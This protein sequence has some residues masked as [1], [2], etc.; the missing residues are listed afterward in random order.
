[1]A[2]FHFWFFFFLFFKH[3]FNGNNILKYSSFEN[4][5]RK[6][7]NNNSDW[8]LDLKF[9]FW[10]NSDAYCDPKST[11]S[12]G[13]LAISFS[14]FSCKFMNLMS[15]QTRSKELQRHFHQQT[16]Y[17]TFAQFKAYYVIL[18]NTSLDDANWQ[19]CLRQV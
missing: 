12:F 1:M 19:D 14:N 8:M 7:V 17:V 3:N 2:K 15:S 5:R 10:I 4:L 18:C 9:Q 16:K 11:F 13:N 6:N